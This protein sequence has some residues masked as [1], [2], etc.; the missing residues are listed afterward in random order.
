M[1]RPVLVMEKENVF[2]K[3]HGKEFT[4]EYTFKSEALLIKPLYATMYAL[5]LFICCYI[6]IRKK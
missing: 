2:S 4:V 1:G 3:F 6:L 5:G